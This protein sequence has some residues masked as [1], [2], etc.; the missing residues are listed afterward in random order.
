MRILLLADVHGNWPALQAPSPNRTT[1]A[2]A[3]AIWWTTDS[4]RGRAST[5]CA[6]T[7]AT[8][9]AATTTTASP[10]TSPSA[11]CNG[12]PLPHRPSPAPLTRERIGED[13]LRTCCACRCSQMVTLDDT[14]FLLIHATPRDPLDEYAPADV[15]VLGSG[16][17]ATW[18]PR[19][20]ASATPTT[21]T[22]WKSATSSSSTPAVFGQPRDGDPR[23]QLRRHR[24][25]QGG[26]E[27]PGISRR[28]DG[29]ASFRR[30]HCRRRR[31]TLAAVFRTGEVPSRLSGDNGKG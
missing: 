1:Y 22:F 19:S 11:A 15:E 2:S 29:A 31:E 28:G 9:C 13:D 26:V 18:R 3:W 24:G 27:A 12:F 20:S 17:C 8:R 7:P 14:R 5:G 16:G 21:P 4:S 30:V 23:G 6:A 25:L 10:R